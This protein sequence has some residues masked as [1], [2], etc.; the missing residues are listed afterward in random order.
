MPE[1]L[2]LDAQGYGDGNLQ[3]QNIFGDNGSRKL[4]SSI[5]GA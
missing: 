2:E 1:Q 5:F 4:A 3:I